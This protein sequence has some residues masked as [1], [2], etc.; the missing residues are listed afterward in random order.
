MDTHT[1]LLEAAEGLKKLLLIQIEQGGADEAQ[2]ALLRRKLL[3]DRKLQNL[4]PRFIRTDTTL[5]EVRR[6]SQNLVPHQS[7]IDG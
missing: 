4:L 1:E 7:W 5:A 2:Y 6:R 3:Q